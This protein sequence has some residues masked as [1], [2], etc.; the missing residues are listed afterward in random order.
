MLFSL[1]EVSEREN[2]KIM[3]QNYKCM[4]A[5]QREK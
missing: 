5:N 4:I 3:P 2:N 1:H